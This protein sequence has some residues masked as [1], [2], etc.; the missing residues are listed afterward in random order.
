[1]KRGILMLL[2]LASGLSACYYDNFSELN[3]GLGLNGCDTTGTI[4]FTAKV[5]PIMNSYCGTGDVSC[6]KDNSSSG[7]YILN[8]KAGV[9]VAIADG[10]FLGAI[11]HDG[12]AIAMPKNGG[13]LDDCSIAIIEKWINTGKAD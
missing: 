12:S 11:K 6:H 9:D 13:K 2:V 5:L 3:P 8:T 7:F 1:M 4:S 10:K